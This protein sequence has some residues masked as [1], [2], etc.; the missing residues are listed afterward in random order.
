MFELIKA[1]QLNIMLGMSSVCLI[2]GVFAAITKSIPKQRKLALVD[3]EFSAAILL[4]SDRLAYIYHGDTSN[5]GYWMVRISNFLVFFMT[6]SVVHALNLYLCD[7]CRNEIGLEKVP[8]RLRL[9]EIISGIG[10]VLVIVTQ[11]T[12]LY[13]TFDDTNAYQRG[14]GFL[15]SYAIPFLALFI[16]L[17]VVF[18]YVKR[19]SLYISIPMLLFTLMPMVA[20]VIQALYYGVSLTRI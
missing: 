17:S 15:I 2:V 14:P 13:Y 1:H 7:L 8:F 6:I 4:F 3:I 10:W 18:Q 20:S 12:G 16:Q 5:M 19:L 11:F 9:V